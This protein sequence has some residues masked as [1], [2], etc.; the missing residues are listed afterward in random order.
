MREVIDQTKLE[1]CV[2]AAFFADMP[3][4]PSSPFADPIEWIS[5]NCH[6]SESDVIDTIFIGRA[7]VRALKKSA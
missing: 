4:S 2:E 1:F 6:M 3:H 7:I 5:A